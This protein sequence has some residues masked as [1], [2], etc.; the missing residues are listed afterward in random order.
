MPV[1]PA[2]PGKP[3]APSR[4]AKRIPVPGK[5][6]TLADLDA[7]R[8]RL[9]EARAHLQAGGTIELVAMESGREL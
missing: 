7:L 4:T 6:A 9:D 5:I 3:A 2:L 8:K 1:K